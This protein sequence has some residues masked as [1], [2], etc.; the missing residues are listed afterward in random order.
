MLPS[1]TEGFSLTL[2]EAMA[3]GVPAIT[4]ANSS[5]GEVANGY[6]H[7]LEDINL[8][9]LSEAMGQVL[10]DRELHEKLK[11]QGLERAK[12]LRWDKCARKTLAILQQVVSA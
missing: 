8:E 5:L 1:N 3:C 9:S 6:A 7:T 2:P 10:C 12:D 4:S 11:Q